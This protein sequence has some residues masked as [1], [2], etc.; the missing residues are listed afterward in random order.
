MDPSLF[1]LILG[2]LIVFFGNRGKSSRKEKRKARH[3][4]HLQSMERAST[5]DILRS[6]KG[7]KWRAGKITQ[8]AIRHNWAKKHRWNQK[9][10][11][12][13][14]VATKC[15]LYMDKHSLGDS[16]IVLNRLKA[17]FN[18]FDYDFSDPQAEAMFKIGFT[19]RE[20]RVRLEELDDNKS[21]YLGWEFNSDKFRQFS[22][23]RGVEWTEHLIH[24]E[25]KRRG[26]HVFNE[27]FLASYK[28]IEEVIVEILNDRKSS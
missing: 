26:K 3:K 22:V 1:W 6:Y 7:I 28:E 15:S 27:L 10:G 24:K 16:E 8:F 20:V 13:Y 25:L 5:R 4:K 19:T 17:L 23:E 14:V 9:S 21:I 2:V 18:K 12:V 11:T